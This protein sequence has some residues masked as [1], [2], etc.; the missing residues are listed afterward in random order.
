MRVQ[1]TIC[2]LSRLDFR[3]VKTDPEEIKAFFKT[4]F[5]QGVKHGAA[6]AEFLTLKN[7]STL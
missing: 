2:L 7:V 5:P 6:T 4:G 1:C 3:Q